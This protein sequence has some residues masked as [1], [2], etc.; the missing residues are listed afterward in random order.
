MQKQSQYKRGR[1]F[2]FSLLLA[3]L[4]LQLPAFSPTANA[5]IGSGGDSPF[6]MNVQAAA[7]YL[8]S[9]FDA[10][11]TKA[12]EAGIGWTREEIRWDAI[13]RF[14]YGRI[15][16]AVNAATSRGINVLGLLG[17]SMD[18]NGNKSI[19]YPPDLREWGAYVREVVARYKNRVKFWQIWNEPDD[20]NYF[21]PAQ[22]YN[23]DL[24]TFLRVSAED[25]G[26]LLSYTYDIIKAEDSGAMVVSAGVSPF[27]TDWLDRMIASGGN[28]KFDVVGFHP[29][30]N[31]PLPLS[32]SS[33]SPE[34]VYWLT[35]NVNLMR[36]FGAKINRPIWATEFGW[37]QVG[38][39]PTNAQDQAN[40]I[41]RAYAL[42]LTA[43]IDKMFVYQYAE[44]PNNSNDRYGIVTSDFVNSKPAYV[45]YKNMTQRLT[46]TNPLGMVE[47][48]SP[49]IIANFEGSA[50]N[51]VCGANQGN[52][53]TYL[54]CFASSEANVILTTT[55][56]QKYTGANSLKVTYSFGGGT[57]DRYV[58]LAT[59]SFAPR[60]ARRVGFWIYG[61]GTQSQFWLNV[62]SNN[63]YSRYQAGRA[64][65]SIAGWQRFEI[66][67][68]L[69][70][71]DNAA[72]DLGSV[73]EIEILI[74]GWPKSTAYNGT[75]FID[76]IYVSNA[77]PAYV[78]RFERGDGKVVD[79]IWT[80]GGSSSSLKIATKDASASYYGRDELNPQTIQSSNGSFAITATGNPTYLVHTPGAATTPPPPPPSTCPAAGDNSLRTRFNPTWE[81]FDEAIITGRASRSWLWGPL[82]NVGRF[83]Q[84]EYD[85]APDKCR[86]VL[87]WDKSRM[88][89]T[90]PTGNTADKYYVTNGL[91][92]REL[93]SGKTQVGN[94]RYLDGS[95]ANVPVAGDDGDNPNA[96]TYA[97]F[98]KVA[99]LNN[100]NKQN[101]RGNIG[102]TDTIDRA[103]T[104]GSDATK[105]GYNV[106]LTRYEAATGHNIAD[107]FW[108][109]MNSSG[110][111]KVNGQYVTGE[112]VDWIY[113]IGLPLTEPYWTRVKVGG[114]EKDVLVQI[115][116]RRA[117]T[118]TPSN[119]AAFQVEMGNIGRHYAI[120]RYGSY[121]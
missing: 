71:F 36:S 104:V 96:P 114:V 8:G 27:R 69:P 42:G 14:G 49:G 91:L 2:L 112:A 88:E 10:V 77:E 106:R 24:N 48:V 32:A 101:N 6:G 39:R 28:G 70:Q 59:K 35:T 62:R 74:D 98:N 23:G 85:S 109:F 52:S 1:W 45:A 9:D 21:S 119:S 80:D 46:G 78:Y 29:Y 50:Q 60:S 26:K 47:T 13:K 89:I 84:E 95:P 100:D 117:L 5:A 30:V 113:S 17:Y 7:R 57:T 102:V 31:D 99:T 25:Y 16:S 105:A 76:D 18:G 111:I 75:I 81:R 68:D 63:G 97:T 65:P 110:P 107:V 58:S 40:Y 33:L 11:F 44:D 38:R 56:E 66:R 12:K 43:G 93:V 82:E 34:S 92:A 37:N 86:T 121:T 90:N 103:G 22:P 118:Y 55:N 19:N 83:T 3:G 15:D 51:N 20:P 94:D 108:T 79:M 54:N 115:F 61:D 64:G 116:E 87:Y 72:P 120:W 73:K 53:G 41:A 67:L 4:F